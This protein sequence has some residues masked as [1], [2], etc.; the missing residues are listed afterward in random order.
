L[1]NGAKS[2]KIEKALKKILDF[3]KRKAIRV[4]KNSVPDLEKKD[5]KI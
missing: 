1:T 5:M 3:Q 2:W 4:M